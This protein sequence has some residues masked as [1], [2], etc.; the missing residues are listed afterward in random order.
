[1]A[2]K[3]GVSV[4][5]IREIASIEGVAPEELE[6]LYDAID[7]DALDE[8][9]RRPDSQHVT[10]EFEYGEYTVRV[11]GPDEITVVRNDPPARSVETRAYSD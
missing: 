3:E 11:E 2:R 10:V 9:V 5:I 8:L 6:P 4:A 1:V 7:T